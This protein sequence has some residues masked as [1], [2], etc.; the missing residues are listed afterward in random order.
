MDWFARGIP[1]TRESA[2][3]TVE[4]SM[5]L[6]MGADFGSSNSS[7]CESLLQSLFPFE[8]LHHPLSIICLF[9]GLCRQVLFMWCPIKYRKK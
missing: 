6:R 4:D 7:V 2:S 9:L 3:E 5:Y 1:F 8:Y